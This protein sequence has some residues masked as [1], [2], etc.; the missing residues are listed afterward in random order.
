MRFLFAANTPRDPYMGASG[1][2]IATIE[3]LREQGHEVDEVWGTDMPRRIGHPNLHQLIE[4]PWNYEQ[5]VAQ[6][7]VSSSYDVVQVN[8]PHAYRAARWYRRSG[9]SGIFVNRSHGWEPQ[10]ESAL[11]AHVD[12]RSDRRPWL[13]KSATRLLRPFLLRHNELVLRHSD[14]VVLCSADDRDFILARCPA[15]TPRLL[16]LAPGLAPAF[17]ANPAPALSAER[18]HR[19]LHVA[20]FNA[21]K[22]PTVVAAVLGTALGA[23]TRLSATWVCPRQFHGNVTELLPPAVRGRIRLLD[24]M[25]RDE[26]LRVYDAHGVF[27]LLSFMEG[28]SVSFLEAMSRGMCV[29]GTRFDGMKQLVRDGE[30]G[31]LVERGDTEVAAARIMHLGRDPALARALAGAAAATVG[32]FTWE[33][34]AREYVDFCQRLLASKSSGLSAHPLGH[35]R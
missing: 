22:A 29:I 15:M 21:C 33:R 8:Q 19:I 11:H 2:D 35:R 18:L 27:L 25:P 1:C 23:D 17:L 31:F 30:N 3:A 13:R 16:V 12:P 7:T 28:F 5:V 26:L 9:R 10:V 32:Q 24:V 20:N 14:G 6:Y 4:L 34:T